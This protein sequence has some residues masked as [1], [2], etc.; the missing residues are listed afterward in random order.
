MVGQVQRM[1]KSYPAL[2]SL[3]KDFF[4]EI[5]R[6][7]AAIPKDLLRVKCPGCGLER[8]GQKPSPQLAPQ[9][10][11]FRCENCQTNYNGLSQ[12][13]EA[14]EC[15]VVT[16]A[17]GDG[18]A[19]PVRVLRSYRDRVLAPRLW[20]RCLILLYL[21]VG[22]LLAASI[23]SR[24]RIRRFTFIAVSGLAKWLDSYGL[25]SG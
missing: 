23:A 13:T 11:T 14:S 10:V 22:P 21:K 8:V 20:G 16:A 4:D 1:E 17:C 24:P 19:Y 12:R 15:F 9:A 2:A 7:A 3:L 5:K 18:N 25:E 6:A